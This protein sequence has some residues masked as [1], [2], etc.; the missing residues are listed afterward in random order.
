MKIANLRLST[1]LSLLIG[2]VSLL[3]VSIS[4]ASMAKMQSLSQEISDMASGPMQKVELLTRL[5]DNYNIIGLYTRNYV[6]SWDANVRQESSK[7]ILAAEADNMTT[8]QALTK[9][10]KSEEELKLLTALNEQQDLYKKKIKVALEMATE[11]KIQG[12]AALLVT[13]IET[14]RL[15]IAKLLDD[16]RNLQRNNVSSS[17][18]R[19]EQGSNQ[20]GIFFIVISCLMI[21]IGLVTSWYASRKLSYI[22]DSI[23]TLSKKIALGDL[24]QS[25]AT[26]QGGEIGILLG[27]LDEMRHSLIDLTRGIRSSAD[28]L[29]VGVEEIAKGNSDLSMRTEQAASSLEETAASM[30]QFTSSINTNAESAKSSNVLAEN[31]YKTAERGGVVVG[32]VV[33]TMREIEESSKKINDIIGVIDGIA[34]QTNILALNAA[35][36]AARAGEQGRGFAVVASEVRSLAQNSAS[37]AKEIKDLIQASVSKVEQGTRLVDEAST[38]MGD[39]VVSAKELTV[40]MALIRNACLEQSSGVAQISQAVSHLDQMTQKNAALVEQSA[41]AAGGMH[42][43]ARHLREIVKKFQLS[44]STD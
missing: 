40:N 32:Q 37:A 9:N 20:A 24:R 3:G 1:Q 7:K 22:L 30:E 5:N 44:D 42:E 11:G 23:I 35:V 10:M 17:S 14:I 15:A 28:E 18:T 8:V 4:L 43:E 19:A 13:E 12:A 26:S 25:V 41:A 38:T 6:L 31:A 33:S 27:S 29:A 34:F 16:G 39:I 2:L 36:E 21:A